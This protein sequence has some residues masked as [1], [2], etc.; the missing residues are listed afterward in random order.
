[1]RTPHA[2]AAER[3][4]PV[5]Y[6]LIS[7]A[8]PQ[9]GQFR[10][11]AQACSLLAGADGVRHLAWS[12]QQR[13]RPD[14]VGSL[15]WVV[16]SGHGAE[17]EARIGDGGSRCL[18]PRDLTLC[19]ETDLYLLACHQGK[20]PLIGEWALGTGATV[21]GCEGETESALSALFLLALLDDGPGSAERWFARWR[22]ANDLLRPHFHELRRMYREEGKDFAATLDAIASFVDLR[23]LDDIVA[24]ARRH[25]P[26]LDGLG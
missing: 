3:S 16:V 17:C 7:C 2:R 9:D 13:L 19:A 12:P 22:E 26:I 18:G 15:R 20:A 6:L 1:M 14:E 8:G 23:A 24:V 11:V 25:D 4:A 21:H 10:G 5:R